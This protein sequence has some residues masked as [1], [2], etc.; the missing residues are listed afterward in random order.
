[1]VEGR[2]IAGA[3]TV[4]ATPAATMVFTSGNEIVGD[5]TVTA[6]VA[7]AMVEGR[8]ISG[9]ITVTAAVAATMVYTPIGGDEIT[10]D[11]TVTAT[12]D[13]MY[14]AYKSIFAS[15]TTR[16]PRVYN[17]D[18]RLPE[19]TSANYEIAGAVTVTATPAAT[20]D[21][22]LSAVIAGAVT[23]TASPAAAMVEG[24]VIA[25]QVNVAVAVAANMLF[26]TAGP[27]IVGDVTVTVT[28]AA[29]M[30]LMVL[31]GTHTVTVAVASPMLY[32][33]VTVAV[34]SSAYR[35]QW[36]AM[37]EGA[38]A[39]QV[40]REL[41]R[42]MRKLQAV[43]SERHVV[44]VF[45]DGDTTP[46]VDGVWFAKTSNL[47]GAVTITTFDDGQV[48]QVLSLKAGDAN[49]TLDHGTSILLKGGIDKTLALGET[50][51]LVCFEPDIWDEV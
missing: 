24:R 18:I 8:V 14:P 25:G 11:V 7:S 22:T 50:I 46:R 31:I 44:A 21:F 36:E 12:P 6:T 20:L 34:D 39:E 30:G 27:E 47:A 4:T 17:I 13:A 1:M 38:S 3:V 41:N 37:P 26:A 16:W 43:L 28:P 33:A 42:R 23:V 19:G 5:V 9:A 29:S 32:T 15:A 2:V 51:T 40:S 45:R 10:G 48:G 49:T 35:W